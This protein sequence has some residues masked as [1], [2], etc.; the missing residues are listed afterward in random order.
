MCRINKEELISAQK[1]THK[2]NNKDLG[3]LWQ[4]SPGM[5]VNT[6]YINSIRGAHPFFRM[7]LRWSNTLFFRLYLWWIHTLFQDVLL[8]DSYPFT[9]CTSGAFISFFR[10]YLWWIYTLFQAGP[11]VD[12]YLFQDVPLADSYPFSWC[13]S[14]G[15]ILFSWCTSDGVYVPCIYTHTPGESC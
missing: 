15:F 12:S 3:R 1:M 7:Y 4:L 9:G 10:M 11:L 8:V 14:G 6:R 13:T 5:R 2:H